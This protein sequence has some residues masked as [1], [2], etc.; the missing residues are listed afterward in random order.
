[1]FVN[2]S[3]LPSFSSAYYFFVYLAV[4]F[5]GLLLGDSV[6]VAIA[7]FYNNFIVDLALGTGI[8]ALMLTLCGFFLLKSNIPIYWMWGHYGLSYFSYTFPVLMKLEF[9]G[10]NTTHQHGANGIVGSEVLKTYGFQHVNIGHNFG[11]LFVFLFVFR[12]KSIYCV[13]MVLQNFGIRVFMQA[14]V[15]VE[16][17]KVTEFFIITCLK[18]KTF[19][20]LI[21]TKCLLFFT[22]LHFFV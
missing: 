6:V 15:H 4:V 7:A 2:V 22:L 19:G 9:D 3:E 20:E 1:M 21:V 16:D 5:F 10:Y 11:I 8:Q 14:L 18:L 13:A 12:R 17:N